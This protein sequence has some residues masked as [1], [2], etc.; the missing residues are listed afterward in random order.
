MTRLVWAPYV[1][2]PLR[3]GPS[4]TAILNLRRLRLHHF[5][6]YK[7]RVCNSSSTS[8]MKKTPNTRNG[9]RNYLRR[10]VLSVAHGQKPLCGTKRETCALQSSPAE[11]TRATWEGGSWWHTVWRCAPA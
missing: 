4:S 3:M 2:E 11:K 7:Q 9:L 10:V 8:T 1:F 5:A 6:N